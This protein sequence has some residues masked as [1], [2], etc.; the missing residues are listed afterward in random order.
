M[1]LLYLLISAFFAFS[2][3]DSAVVAADDDTKPATETVAAEGYTLVLVSAGETKLVTVK[4]I[5]ETLGI[6][7]KEAKE[8][9]DNAP[10]SVIAS[11]LS[12]EDAQK[13]Y[14]ALKEAGIE[15]EMTSPSL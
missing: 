12:K 4:T 1:K 13:Y 5:K 14:D 15:V 11:G 9:V 3:P 6:G 10:N 7:L 8:I 2:T